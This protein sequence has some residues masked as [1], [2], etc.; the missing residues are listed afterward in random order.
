VS[1]CAFSPD[2]NRIVSASHDHTLKVWDAQTG[3]ELHTLTGHTDSVFGCA[4][5]PDGRRIVSASGDHTLKVWDADNGGL[6]AHLELPAA[7]GWVSC[8][9]WRPWVTC[10]DLSGALYRIEVMGIELGPIVVTATERGPQLMVRC[11]ACQSDHAVERAGLGQV[12]EC[13]TPNCGLS[14]RVNPFIT[15]MASGHRPA[16]E[17]AASRGKPILG[18]GHWWSRK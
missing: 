15:R 16:L 18:R 5:S 7:S 3:T 13:P 8:H 9:P 2:G 10:G 6:V 4:F 17:S 14:L 11:P 12:I 1:G